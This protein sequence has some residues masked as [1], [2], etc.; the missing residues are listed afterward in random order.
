MSPD[1]RAR[2]AEQ[3]A[4]LVDALAGRSLAPDGFDAQ[5]VATAVAS[6]LAKRRRGVEKTW[7]GL[8]ESL[9][10]RFRPVFA[11]YA[12]VQSIPAD[13]P[14]ADG[15]QFARHLRRLGLLSDDGRLKLLLAE[16]GRWPISIAY[17]RGRRAV[18]VAFR[19]YSGARW[20]TVPLF[21][22]RRPD[23]SQ[24]LSPAAK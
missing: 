17:L 8:G 11:E 13:G 5:H 2:L 4:A 9:G 12:R 19:T 16:M 10:D 14:A 22:F 18:A 23:F 20:F 6:L 21:R 24:P 7:P 3:Q 15:R 1:D